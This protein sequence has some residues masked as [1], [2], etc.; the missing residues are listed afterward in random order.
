MKIYIDGE[1][2]MHSLVGV[3]QRH[4]RVGQRKELKAFDLAGLCREA[5][6]TKDVT[7]SYYTTKLKAAHADTHDEFTA[8]KSKEII[9]WAAGWNSMLVGQGISVVRAGNLK[10]REAFP[11]P[12]CGLTRYVFQEKGV[13][14][15]LAVDVVLESDEGV[16]QA[17]FSSDSDLVAAVRA[18][19]VRGARV[20]NI[21]L[22]GGF[23]RGLALTCGEWQLVTDEQIVAAYDRAQKDKKRG[24]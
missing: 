5:V 22:K 21:S 3:L 10:I 20:K 19:K 24:K 14:V 16:H 1:N 17:I 2:L 8:D 11:C 15:Q 6:G 12:Q 18:A 23:N 4:G 7:I 13:D 9:T